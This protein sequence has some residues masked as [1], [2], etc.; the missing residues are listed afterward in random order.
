M[1]VCV[2]AGFTQLKL[3]E[4]SM[5]GDLLSR[6]LPSHWLDPESSSASVEWV[7]GQRSQPPSGWLEALW[8]Y[9]RLNCPYDLR[10]VETFP[11]VPVRSAARKQLVAGT[12]TCQITELVALAGPRQGAVLIR[13]ADGISLGTELE[14]IAGKLGM[15]VV[16]APPD[17]IRAHVVVERDYLFAPT[18]MGMLRA[19]QRQCVTNGRENTLDALTQRTTASEKRRLRELFAKI[20]PHELHDDYHDLLAGLPLF[21]TLDGSGNRPSHFVSAA[22]VSLAAP[23]ERTSIP[24]S[25]VSLIPGGTLRICNNMGTR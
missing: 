17:Y 10:A 23:A 21:E 7:A 8:D 1:C 16:D 3:V 2:F 19:V 18:Y 12:G 25:Q 11:L 6:S 13:R 14:T 20:S 22:E 4:A 24:L 5:I 15:L 9:L